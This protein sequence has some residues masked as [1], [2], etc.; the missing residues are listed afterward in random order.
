MPPPKSEPLLT[1]TFKLTS[2]DLDRLDRVAAQLARADRSAPNRTRALRWAIRE[3]SAR[4][5]L[6]EMRR[7]AGEFV[8]TDPGPMTEPPE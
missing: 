3:L 8:A 6:D 4:L 5:H 2:V 7:A 1:T